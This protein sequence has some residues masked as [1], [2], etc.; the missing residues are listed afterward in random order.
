MERRIEVAVA[1]WGTALTDRD[2]DDG[3]GALQTQLDRDFSPEWGVKAHLFPL[4]PLAY[5]SD[6]LGLIL[7]KGKS[8]DSDHYEA[9]SAGLPLVEVFPDELD[10]GQQWTHPAS[11]ELLTM[12]VDAIAGHGVYWQAEDGDAR[13]D[14]LYAHEIT[15]PCAS[16]C[17]GYA[18]GGWQVSDFVHRAWFGATAPLRG[19]DHCG[20]IHCAF[21][22]LD[23]E[24][25]FAYD[26]RTGAWFEIGARDRR[27][28]PAP[29]GRRLER[30]A[31]ALKEP[32]RAVQPLTLDDDPG[33]PGPIWG[34]P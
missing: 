13:T 2:I 30:L 31:A 28:V 21:D 24:R 9:T 19:Y 6:V 29:S 25:V 32:H 20:R 3:I 22:V 4:R 14:R 18:I 11:R 15:A 5:R 16:Y 10:A 23:G 34:G 17:H 12:L 8:A 33:P 7:R 26:L 1:N 27:E